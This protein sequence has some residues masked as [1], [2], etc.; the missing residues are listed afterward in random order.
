[1]AATI[2]ATRVTIAMSHTPSAWLIAIGASV[3]PMT[4][5]T[6]PVTIG[7]KI[8]R[9]NPGPISITRPAMAR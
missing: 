6:G 4:A 5:I 1:M 7:G 3:I 2:V 8:F 9:M